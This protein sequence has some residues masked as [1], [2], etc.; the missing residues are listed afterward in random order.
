MQLQLES[1][2]STLATGYCD[3]GFRRPCNMKETYGK[4]LTD[5]GGL[6]V[7]NVV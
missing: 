7:D 2:T 3:K 1:L 5:K 4:K 6:E